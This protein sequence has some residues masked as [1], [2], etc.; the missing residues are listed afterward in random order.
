[1]FMVV[2]FVVVMLHPLAVSFSLSLK[3]YLCVLFG[4]VSHLEELDNIGMAIAFGD[5]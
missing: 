3:S 5:T 4:V 1:M 2:T